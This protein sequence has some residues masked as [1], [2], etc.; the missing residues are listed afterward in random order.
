MPGTSP[1]PAQLAAGPLPYPKDL[2][3]TVIVRDGTPIAL[4]PVRPEDE[5]LLRD[6]FTHMSREDVRLRFFAPIRELSHRFA[7]RL[8]HIDYDREMA[9][10]A[11]HDGATLGV[12]RYSAD[13]DKQRA[14]FAIA[15][16][17]DWKGH[18]VG[19]LL[20]TRLI[21]IARVA[22]IGELFGDV[23]H[24]NQPMLDMCRELGFSVAANPKD[25]TLVT[26]RK[27]LSAE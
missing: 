5:P 21:E 14:E 19:Y 23:L 4:R 17:S 24:E 12:A 27:S 10:S 1:R 15:V 16:R 3:S 11:Q 13:P 22:G 8:L 2:E 26:V 9:L 20:M 25:W 6:L 7:E 18:G